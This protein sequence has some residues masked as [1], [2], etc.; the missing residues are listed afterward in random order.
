MLSTFRRS[1]LVSPVLSCRAAAKLECILF[2]GSART[3][4]A[5]RALRAAGTKVGLMMMQEIDTHVA[6]P[7]SYRGS[8]QQEGVNLIV[9]AG[10]G[11][12]TGDALMAAAVFLA[13]SAKRY[14]ASSICDHV[15]APPAAVAT[16]TVNVLHCFDSPACWD[17][18]VKRAMMT[19]TDVSAFITA[20]RNVAKTAETGFRVH[21]HYL[22]QEVAARAKKDQEEEQQ[23]QQQQQQNP[24]QLDDAVAAAALEKAIRLGGLGAA[25]VVLDGVFG[26]NFKP[27]LRGLAKSVIR[28]V[29]RQPA[30]I[31][32]LRCA[33]DVPSGVGDECDSAENIFRADVTFAT[34]IAKHPVTWHKMA[35]IVGRLR[36]ADIDFFVPRSEFNY[37]IPVAAAV[38]AAAAQSGDGHESAMLFDVHAYVEQNNDNRWLA[39]P[40]LLHSVCL[41][42]RP[43]VCHKSTYGHCLIVGGS[44]QRHQTTAASEATDG[45]MCTTGTCMPGALIMAA[46][47]ALRSGC[48]L[49]TVA[50]PEPVVSVAAALLPEVMWIVLPMSAQRKKA[51]QEDQQRCEDALSVLK[52]VLEAGRFTSCL[53]GPG[54]GRNRETL[55][56]FNRLPQLFLSS[57][58]SCETVVFDADSLQES[59]VDHICSA[60]S[61]SS[62]ESSTKFVL[63][64]HAGELARLVSSSTSNVRSSSSTKNNSVELLL[65]RMGNGRCII[66]EKGE[67]TAVWTTTTTA[68]FSE[69]PGE[70]RS[71]EAVACF[72]PAG[73]PVLARGGSGDVLAGLIAGGLSATCVGRKR[74]GGDGMSQFESVILSTLRHA[75]AADL[76]ARKHGEL[77]AKTCDLIECL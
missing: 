60:I 18:G 5:E 54:M 59:L 31:V 23:Q 64:P 4:V 15:L 3:I 42:P 39:S 25:V 26:M 52:G 28:C 24:T 21:N 66:V 33:V 20:R 72:I 1:G 7:N 37:P 50:A 63:T 10:R 51:G 49:L 65:E 74:H 2:D 17:D 53:I 56:L 22:V 61:T 12:N 76:S 13:E 40:S 77:A 27:P 67:R 71:T 29:N 43:A 6:T 58:S 32:R 14:E 16:A 35:S 19:L 41:G 55:E 62:P 11:N 9:L 68:R 69:S 34:G 45:G 70:D 48:G 73:G 46:Q 44:W 47:A 57:S 36:F 75:N 8:T 30:N 38:A